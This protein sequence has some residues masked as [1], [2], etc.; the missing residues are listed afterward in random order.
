MV[1]RTSLLKIPPA[2]PITIAKDEELT[3]VGPHPVGIFIRNTL[4]A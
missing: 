4:G 3:R 2:A 1:E